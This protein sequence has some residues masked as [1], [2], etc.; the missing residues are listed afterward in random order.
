[1]FR[2]YTLLLFKRR[3]H[4][5]WIRQ[6]YRPTGHSRTIYYLNH[7]SWWDGL[8]PFLLN[9][10]RF[11]QNARAL[12]EDQQIRR[13]PFFSKIGA[14]SVDRQHPRKTVTSMRYAVQ[15]MMRENAS[16]FIYPEGKINP[17][18]SPIAFEGGLAWLY[19]RM[20]REVIDFVPVAIKIHTMHHDKPELFI[21]VGESAVPGPDLVPDPDL[22]YGHVTEYFE[23]QLQ[24]LIGRSI[25]ST[26]SG[27]NS[28]ERLV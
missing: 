22:S 16:L 28:F 9:E 21:D 4:A 1:M 26:N 11:H 23:E 3:F 13:Y 25:A 14:F 17:A 5:V 18:G 24:R 6:K 2:W 12:M 7:N 10:F 20:N 19:S 27:G 8:I 15:S